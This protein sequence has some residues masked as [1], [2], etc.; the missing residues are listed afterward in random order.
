MLFLLL[1]PPGTLRRANQ[2]S[3]GLLVPA[4]RRRRPVRALRACNQKRAPTAGHELNRPR[5]CRQY[6]KA[7]GAGIFGFSRSGAASAEPTALGVAS[8]L[9]YSTF[10][11]NL[12]RI[13]IV[14]VC[15]I[16]EWIFVFSETQLVTHLIA[17]LLIP[18]IA[19]YCRFISSHCIDVIPLTPKYA[20]SVFILH[21]RVS[22]EDHKGTFPLEIS[23]KIR[24][25]QFGWNRY[26]HMD[27]IRHC[28][29]LNDF[30]MFVITKHSQYLPNI[31][32]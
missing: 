25:C 27:G 21:V 30:H 26:Q 28:M 19:F 8:L 16:S 7:P 10:C 4:L 1:H 22:F 23:Y 32:A 13:V 12:W 20:P 29:G 2:Q 14:K 11:W 5:L 24:H 9:A 18:N 6:K 3:T 15:Y 31:F 17:H